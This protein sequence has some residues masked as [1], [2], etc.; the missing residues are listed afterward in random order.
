MATRSIYPQGK[1]PD[2]QHF[3]MEASLFGEDGRAEPRDRVIVDP[4]SWEELLPHIHSLYLRAEEPPANPRDANRDRDRDRHRD[5]DRD[6]ERERPRRDA[7]RRDERTHGGTF[8]EG[9]GARL[10]PRESPG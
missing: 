3:V 8:V 2:H 5:R 9:S 6:R 10:D 4:G 1:I 7:E